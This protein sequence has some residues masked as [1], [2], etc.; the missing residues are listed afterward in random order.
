MYPSCSY[1][2]AVGFEAEGQ[3]P[4]CGSK[5]AV[6]SPADSE[7]LLVAGTCQEVVKFTLAFLPKSCSCAAMW[8]DAHR[9]RTSE[10]RGARNSLGSGQLGLPFLSRSERPLPPAPICPS[11]FL[12]GGE[13][14]A[15]PAA[16]TCVCFLIG[17]GFSHRPAGCSGKNKELGACCWRWPEFDCC[18][19]DLEG[20]A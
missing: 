20:A 7:P 5:E 10:L 11:V 13:N 4:S 3:E 12:G 2:S 6:G 17:L 15:G 16:Y 19:K 1:F 9:P 18:A 8:A 14:K